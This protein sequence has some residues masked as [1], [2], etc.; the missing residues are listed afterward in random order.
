[1]RAFSVAQTKMPEK[2][3]GGTAE[4][5]RPLHRDMQGIFFYSNFKRREE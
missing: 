4:M 3:Q 5:I 1:M 2:K